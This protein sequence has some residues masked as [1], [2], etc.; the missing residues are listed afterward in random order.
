MDDSIG[1]MSVSLLLSRLTRSRPTFRDPGSQAGSTR[2]E[3]GSR[4]APNLLTGLLHPFRNLSMHRTPHWIQSTGK[5]LAVDDRR[6]EASQAELKIIT[7][8]VAPYKHALK[9]RPH[10]TAEP[11]ISE[12]N[13]QNHVQN[14]SRVM[15]VADTGTYLERDVNFDSSVGSV[16]IEC[17]ERKRPG[18]MIS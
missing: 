14:Q 3:H 4:Q 5:S 9:L 18:Y 17:I 16:R 2:G 8:R 15:L 1:Q 12:S 7:L 11:K 6:F 10:T 13:P